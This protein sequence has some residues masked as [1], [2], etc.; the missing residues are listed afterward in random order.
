MG[1]GESWSLQANRWYGGEISG[2]RSAA[3]R[4][5]DVESDVDQ[6]MCF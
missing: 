2:R 4:R 1:A 5:W 3:S 6:R